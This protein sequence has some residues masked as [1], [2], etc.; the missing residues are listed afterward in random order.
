MDELMDLSIKVSS[1]CED[2]KAIIGNDGTDLQVI[3]KAEEIIHLIRLRNNAWQRLWEA[4]DGSYKARCKQCGF[5]TFFV[6]GHD[7]Q[8]RYCPECGEQ[9]IPYIIPNL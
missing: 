1:L 5:V 4:P 8:Y 7:N 3:G 6:E 9:K 2:I